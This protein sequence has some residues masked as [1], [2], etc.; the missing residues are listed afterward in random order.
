M[1]PM[2]Q[3]SLM[4]VVVIF[5]IA[6]K[7]I[8][9]QRCGIDALYKKTSCLNFNFLKTQTLREDSIFFIP[10]VVHII[11]NEGE[12]K[13]PLHQVYSQIYALNR[14]FRRY[15]Y[16]LGYGSGV[17]MEIEFALAQRT[18]EGKVCSGI[19]YIQSPLTNHRIDTAEIALKSLIHW[20]ADQYLNV[21]VVRSIEDASGKKYLGYAR[22][23]TRD[24]SQYFLD[25]VVVVYNAF[26]TKGTLRSE[27]NQGRTLTH[28]VG[29]WLGL[30][31]TFQDSCHFNC[32][33]EGDKICDTP[34]TKGPNYNFPGRQNTCLESE[35]KP[36][37]TRNYMDYGNDAH[38][39]IFTREQKQWA[40]QV[41]ITFPE[42]H[43]IWQ[44]ENLEKTGI[45]K[46][47]PPLAFFTSNTR[48]SCIG[49][50]IKF[51]SLALQNASSFEWFFEGGNP[52]FSSEKN[53][54][55][56]YT[57]A[58]KFGVTLIVKNEVGIRDTLRWQNYI[59][60]LDTVFVLPYEEGFEGIIFPPVGWS[61]VDE[62][63]LTFSSRTFTRSP[64]NGNGGKSRASA[65]LNF[66]NYNGYGQKDALLSP[67]FDVQN[68][69]SLVIRFWY[70]YQGLE[71]AEGGYR[72]NYSDTLALYYSLDCG[73]S[74][75]LIWKKGGTQLATLTP[76]FGSTP[77]IAVPPD[78]WKKCEVILPLDNRERNKVQ[79]RLETI[80]G[81]GNN[82]YVDDFEVR[83]YPET[84]T[85]LDYDMRSFIE[86]VI[87]W[88]SNPTPKDKIRV[89]FFLNEGSFF[90]IQVIDGLGRK[91]YEKQ[92]EK[93][94]AGEYILEFSLPCAGYYYL[95][96]L[97]RDRRYA[98][99][100]WVY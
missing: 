6:L 65:R 32:A 53:P 77:L 30:A 15:P 100:L 91:H 29:H 61:I 57:R 73:I 10:L 43:R 69:D 87:K 11:H 25:G 3:F 5:S 36:D 54:I 55:V 62:D 24:S 46:E 60:I 76:E 99:K 8:A 7:G 74:W 78:N 50:S 26:G 27:Y 93:G 86:T 9:Q 52:D 45:L 67:F 96:L 89:S 51:R 92:E 4:V 12:E 42:R 41:L 44:K 58:G 94:K 56:Q 83:P 82:L 63:E 19:N 59:T 14:D 75:N 47:A 28:E 49:Q 79:F 16:T 23:P 48:I 85:D 20:P 97:T 38:L 72:Y 13:I 90:N 21:W 35:D 70:A 39:D 80:N 81:F 66:F 84:I 17:D 64:T 95:S 22:Y 68:L 71:S 40:H 88:P 98:T 34:P 2:V 1:V 37:Q 18:P 31:H 33:L